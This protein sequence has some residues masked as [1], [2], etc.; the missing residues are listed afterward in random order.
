MTV[1]EPDLKEERRLR[2]EGH[3]WVA[4]LDEVGRGAWAGPLTVGVAVVRPRVQLRSMP[5]WLRDSKMLSEAR[6]EEIFGAVGKWLEAW[7]VGH[8]T[9]F[10]CDRWGMT[11][12]L[13]VAARRALAGLQQAPDALLI[14]GPVNL[15]HRPGQ[16]AVAEPSG[17]EHP[18][19]MP[20]HQV[21]PD[22]MSPHAMSP[23][24]MWSDT[25]APPT[26][27]PET[28]W[29]GSMW[30][31][32]VPSEPLAPDAA[33]IDALTL[34]ALPPDAGPTGAG[35]SGAMWSDPGGPDAG[36]QA[37]APFEG[38]A[39][40]GVVRPI[41]DGDA[42]C[43]SVAA[44]SVLAKVVR[45]RIMREEADH[46]PAYGFERNKGYPSLVHQTALRGYGPSAIHRRSW[47]FMEELPWRGHPCPVRMQISC[48]DDRQGRL[49][50]AF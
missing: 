32:A 46:F 15:L 28:V 19:R 41:V 3:E 23:E 17:P 1:C 49:F 33:A 47:A 4:G 24:T 22:S 45:D 35:A 34:G 10:E 18:D 38:E 2:R 40:G 6:R 27:S 50:P 26:M 44:A 42:K 13:R 11:E 30:S 36:P 43:A 37:P 31:D 16:T 5:A 9:S 48:V 7:S 29:S 21:S 20:R 39:F 12:A 14:D 25:M 8:A